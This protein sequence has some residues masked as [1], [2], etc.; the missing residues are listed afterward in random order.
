MNNSNVLLDSLFDVVWTKPLACIQYKIIVGN[1]KKKR[2]EG[3]VPI[4]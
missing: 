2:M 4:P 1:D 3:I